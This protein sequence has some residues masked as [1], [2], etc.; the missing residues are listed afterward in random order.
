MKNLPVY[1]NRNTWS[2]LRSEWDNL[3][4]SFNRALNQSQALLPQSFDQGNLFPAVDVVE[5]KHAYKIEAEMPGMGEDDVNVSI[6]HNTLRIKGEKSTS[7]QDQDKHYVNREITYGCYERTIPLPEYV[8]T[9]KATAS[10]KKGMLWVVI[11]KSSDQSTSQR[12]IQVE[13]AT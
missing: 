1:H 9:D 11:P 6:D 5:D 7:K 10:F 2:L 13:K 4:D 12:T 3:I 8:D